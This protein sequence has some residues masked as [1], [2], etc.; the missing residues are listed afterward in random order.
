MADFYQTL[1]VA[2]SASSTEIR[3]AFRKLARRYHPDTNASDRAAEEKFKEA[4]EA[5]RTLSDP[6]K[7]K[8][9]DEM[10]RLGAFDSQANGGSGPDRGGSQGFD[11]RM[12]QRA[13]QTF[14]MADFGDILANLFDSVG[15][16]GSP[17]STRR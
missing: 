9:Y 14:Q 17:L 16:N 12:F 3:K 7:R 2:R 15:Q 11:S 1:G 6:D 8:E 5:H 13:E 4:N 10:L